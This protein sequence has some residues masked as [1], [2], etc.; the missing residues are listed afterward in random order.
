MTECFKTLDGLY[1]DHRLSKCCKSK[2]AV[3][4]GEDCS[5]YICSECHKPCDVIC[6]TEGSY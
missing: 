4:H 6:D 5:Y 1:G 2:V 3:L